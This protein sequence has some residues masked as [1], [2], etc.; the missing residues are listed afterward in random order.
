M[1]TRVLCFTMLFAFCTGPIFA[2]QEKSLRIHQVGINFSSLNSFGLHYKTG[3]EKTLLRL[4]LLSL[5]LT[6]SSSWGR[7][8][9][10]IDNKSNQSGAGF[11]LGFEKQVPIV[12]KLNFIWGL[13]AG[14]NY[15]YGKMKVESG[16][17]F[18]KQESTS[19]SVT[20]L[21]NLVLGITYSISD[22]IV[23]GAEIL[24]MISY[25]YGKTHTTIT[26]PSYSRETEETSSTFSFGL[27]NSSAS[28]TL[29]YRFGK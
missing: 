6:K 17:Y 20:P 7:P 5:N 29:A 1:K 2:Q 27:T 9:D 15:N 11:R 10:S 18:N 4:S 12:A 14:C 24:P 28:L 21:I 25:S 19:W 13:E 26:N 22:H 3:N 8:Q 23:I 16:Y